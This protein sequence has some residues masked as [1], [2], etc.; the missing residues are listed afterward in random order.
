MG[1]SFLQIAT[2][3]KDEKERNS[4]RKKNSD[5]LG[6]IGTSLG[7]NDLESFGWLRLVDGIH[8]NH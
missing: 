2:E 1:S 4:K 5:T 7:C 3:L 8:G 6:R